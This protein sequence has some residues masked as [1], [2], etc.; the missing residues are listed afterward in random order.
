MDMNKIL[1]LVYGWYVWG[2]R[3]FFLDY[4]NRNTFWKRGDPLD[5]SDKLKE[6]T[7]RGFDRVAVNY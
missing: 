3:E 1:Q 4:T 6:E 5:I 2:P 7:R